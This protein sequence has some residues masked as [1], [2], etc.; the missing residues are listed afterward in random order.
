MIEPQ[1]QES[2]LDLQ[3]GTLYRH[4]LG[5]L[6]RVEVSDVEHANSLQHLVIIRALTGPKKGKAVAYALAQ[7]DL[8]FRA[9]PKPQAEPVPEKVAGS[10]DIGSGY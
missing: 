4:Q 7:F 5:S 6:W 3:P 8:V 1:I 9:E 10:A 2:R